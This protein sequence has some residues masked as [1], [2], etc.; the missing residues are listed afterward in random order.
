M[1]L[2][3]VRARRNARGW[4]A[5][6]DDG[7]PYRISVMARFVRTRFAEDDKLMDGWVSL[8]IR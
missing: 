3:P 6:A 7:D 1:G 8:D 2:V 4:G 5:P